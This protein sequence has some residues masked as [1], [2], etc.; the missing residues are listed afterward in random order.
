MYTGHGV[1]SYL[2]MAINTTIQQM[3]ISKEEIFTYLKSV[4]IVLTGALHIGAHD[5]EEVDVYRHLGIA[6]KRVVWIDAMQDK[7]NEA[8]QRGVP[9]VYQAVVSD[10]DGKIVEFKRTNNGQ[11]SSILEFGTHATHY[12]WCVVTERT[13]METTTV[14]TFMK[15]NNLNPANYNFWNFDIQGAE[16]LALKG[17]NNALRYAKVLYLEVN[18]EDVY[19]GCAKMNEIDDYL[20]ARGFRRILTKMVKEGWGDAMYVRIPLIFDIGANV[21]RYALANYMDNR[22][23]VVSVEAS[24]I[25]FNKLKEATKNTSIDTLNYAI[26][27]SDNPTVAFH[28]CHG[29]DVLSTTDIDWLTSPLS[30]FGN[31]GNTIQTIQVP[32][33]TLDKLVEQ[34]WIPDI[35]KIDV[36]GSEREVISS[37]TKKIPVLCFEWAAEWNA[38]TLAAIDHLFSLGFTKFHIQERDEYTYSPRVFEHSYESVKNALLQKTHRV[39]WGMVWAQ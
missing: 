32:T 6:D 17:A 16:L 20:G 14:D 24:P 13:Q 30:R 22:V 28:H 23:K 29:A 3:L 11:S 38:K 18:T 15:N 9:N 34:Y 10:E 33:M 7:V 1:V 21:G 36:E 8:V 26:T 12:S 31:Y 19:I 25:T 37:L 2:N 35:V 27:G 39:D 5:C 4:N